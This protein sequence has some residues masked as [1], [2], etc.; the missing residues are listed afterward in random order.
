MITARQI[1]RRGLPARIIRGLFNENPWGREL[2]V[3]SAHRRASDLNNTGLIADH[4]LATLKQ[5]IANAEKGDTIIIGPEHAETIVAADGIDINV[6]NLNIYGLGTG[7]E[8]PTFTVS[9]LTTANMLISAAGVSMS[10]VILKPGIDS[11]ATLLEVQ[12][13]GVHLINLHIEHDA[14]YQAVIGISA[15]AAADDLLI[16]ALTSV[17]GDAGA[18]ACVRL[19]GG[20][21]ATVRNCHLQGDYASGCIYGVTTAQ[22]NCLIHNCFL[23]SVNAADTVIN[24]VATSTGFIAFNS[25]RI[26]TDAQT[27][28]IVAADCQW[29]QNYGVNVDGETGVLIGT[30]SA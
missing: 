8:R 24:L 18:A 23:E 27:S 26:A 9:T 7:S 11:V 19:V 2:Y 30:P 21:N 29:F 10:N 3:C 12:A 6:E 20:A 14:T 16:D 4:P 22:T 15:N 1:G 28:W 17:Q 25:C 5:A 13:A